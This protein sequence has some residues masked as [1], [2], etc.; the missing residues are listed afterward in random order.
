MGFTDWSFNSAPSVNQRQRSTGSGFNNWNSSP[1]ETSYDSGWGNN[2]S[3]TD[4]FQNEDWSVDS[5][6]HTSP[7][8]SGTKNPQ[9]DPERTQ[10]I[11]YLEDQLYYLRDDVR[12]GDEKVD[13]VK[14]KLTE[15]R[16]KLEETKSSAYEAREGHLRLGNEKAGLEG[17]QLGNKR[18]IR[19]LQQELQGCTDEWRTREILSELN[20][21]QDARWTISD[22]IMTKTDRYRDTT[23]KMHELERRVQ[24]L[25]YEIEQQVNNVEN[26]R[27]ERRQK[28]EKLDEYERELDRLKGNSFW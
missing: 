1:A 2:N 16:Y 8:T 11:A 28:K 3:I 24:E 22:Q 26:A 9:N 17:K 20:Q 18:R 5:W 4:G 21:R 13:A 12:T 23:S 10:R 6:R 7:D 14:S 19:E 15:L 25:D 27:K